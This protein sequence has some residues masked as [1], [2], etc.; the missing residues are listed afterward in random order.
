MEWGDVGKIIAKIAPLAGTALLGPAGGVVGGIIASLFGVDA[1]PDQVVQAIQADP[2]AALK[3]K[4]LE[5]NH[6]LELEK[7]ILDAERMRLA[8]VA[9]A[10]RRE[11]EGTKVTGKRD[12]NLYMLA[13]VL[14]LGF[15]ALVA[16]LIF[17][18]LPPDSS[19]V[20]YMLFGSLSAGFVAVTQYFFGSSKG[21]DDKTVLLAKANTK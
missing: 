18:A 6:K 9:D 1:A 5:F 14:V 12:I 11:V 21:S 2:Q 19:G 20:I 15:F 3:L 7:M 17:R 4:E 8:D 16:T 10:R 13:W